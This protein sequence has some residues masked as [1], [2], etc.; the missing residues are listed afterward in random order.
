MT[1]YETDCSVAIKGRITATDVTIFRLSDKL[2][3]AFIAEGKITDIPCLNTACR[4]QAEIELPEKTLGLL[5]THPL[6]NHLLLTPGKYARILK[7]ACW[8]KGIR[9]IS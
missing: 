5:R 4:T 9:V 3:R 8:Y 6:G 2:D 1:H 7:T